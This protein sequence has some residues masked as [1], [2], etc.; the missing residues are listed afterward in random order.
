MRRNQLQHYFERSPGDPPP[1]EV[2]VTRR[3]QFSESDP[4]GIAWHGN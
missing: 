4:L 3:L 2:S 1:I